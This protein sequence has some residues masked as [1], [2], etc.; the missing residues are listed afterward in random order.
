MDAYCLQEQYPTDLFPIWEPRNQ[1]IGEFFV[2]QE[3]RTTYFEASNMIGSV[4]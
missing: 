2:V 3:R 4:V 1:E